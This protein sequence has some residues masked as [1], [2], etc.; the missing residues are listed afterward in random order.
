MSSAASCFAGDSTGTA[1]DFVPDIRFITAREELFDKVVAVCPIG[2]GKELSASDREK[3]GLRA[4]TLVY[5][6]IKFKPFAI[7]LQKLR[8]LYGG[9]DKPGLK[10]YDLGSGTGKAVFAAALLHPWD[11][12]T[13]EPV[14]LETGAGKMVQCRVC[15]TRGARSVLS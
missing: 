3:L 12:C 11:T 13:G 4:S 6:E 10:F 9:L 15:R 7:A 14:E 8:D 5:G 2:R 1:H